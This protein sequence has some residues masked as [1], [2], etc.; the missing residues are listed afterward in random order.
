[1]VSVQAAIEFISKQ[2]KQNLSP[3]R[4]VSPGSVVVNTKTNAIFLC[5]M[6]EIGRRWSLYNI[7]TGCAY[8]KPFVSSKDA[9]D[10]LPIDG[11][12]IDP[13]DHIVFWEGKVSTEVAAC[14]PLKTTKKYITKQEVLTMDFE[15][16]FRQIIGVPIAEPEYVGMGS[17]LK[18]P[19]KD[20]YIIAQVE[21]HMVNLISLENGNRWTAAVRVENPRKFCLSAIFNTDKFVVVYNSFISK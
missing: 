13:K 1:M 15:T 9:R 5:C 20:Y 14:Q 11:F 18:H 8:G 7:N 17:I 3:V 21:P 4:Q 16:R 12:G 6:V 19:N 10:G 2:P